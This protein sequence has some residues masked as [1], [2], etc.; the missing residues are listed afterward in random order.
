MPAFIKTEKDEEVWQKARQRVDDEYD[1]SEQGENYWKLV[2]SIYH[3][4]RKNAELEI[5]SELFDNIKDDDKINTLSD[6]VITELKQRNYIA[7]EKVLTNQSEEI[8]KGGIDLMLDNLE[9]LFKD[10]PESYKELVDYWNINE[11]RVGT[12]YLIED[13]ENPNNITFKIS[14]RF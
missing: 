7:K 11:F 3:K 4:M 1:Y 13:L 12:L 2:N 8:L 6:D 5:A 9:S 14:L 10:Y